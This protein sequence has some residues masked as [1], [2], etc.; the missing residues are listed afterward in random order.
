MQAP[1]KAVS[2]PPMSHRPRRAGR[3]FALA[4]AC[5]AAVLGPVGWPSPALAQP[6]GK[7]ASAALVQ[8]GSA[9]F[10]DQQYEE[11]IQ[12]LSAALV[13]PGATDAEKIEIYRLLAYNFIILKRADEADAAVRG[14]LGLDE[15]FTLPPTESPRFRDFFAATRRKWV[16]EGKPGG[17]AAGPAAVVDKPI[18]MT[19]A[20]PAEMPAGA[21][22]RLSGAVEDPDAR[23]RAVQ[24]AYRTGAKGKF[25]TVAGSYTLGEFHANIPGVAVK[26]PLV[27]YYVSAVDKGGLPLASRGDAALPLRIVVQREGGALTSPFLWVPVALAVVA[28]AATGVYFLTRNKAQATVMVGVHE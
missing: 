7:S 18:K 15:N 17:K 12:T 4:A 8:R 19:H 9:L 26:P 20:S 11:S 1:A 6:P 24:L 21:T 2:L 23:V 3:A 10:E 27:E 16:E 22:I 13:R 25:V 14:V 28:G 5:H